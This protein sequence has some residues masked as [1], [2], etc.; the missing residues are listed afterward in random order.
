[1]WKLKEPKPAK[2]I[3]GILASNYQCLHAA[4]ESLT[5]IWRSF[6]RW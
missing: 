2:L 5:R 6:Q 4:T 3:V 1:M